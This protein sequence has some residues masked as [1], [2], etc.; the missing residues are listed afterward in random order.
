MP[1]PFNLA[2]VNSVQ[3]TLILLACKLSVSLSI[4]EAFRKELPKS[5]HNPGEGVHK[6]MVTALHF[7]GSLSIQSHSNTSCR[8]NT[9]VCEKGLGYSAM[10]TLRSAH[11]RL[12][13]FLQGFHLENYLLL[14]IK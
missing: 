9:E 3:Q 8:L 1:L 2:K 10:N 7:K 4:Q 11:H 12:Y 14:T 6:Q 13:T 5:Y